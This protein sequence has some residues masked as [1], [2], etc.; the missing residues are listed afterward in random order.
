M[1]EYYLIEETVT[2]ICLYEI[3]LACSELHYSYKL[4]P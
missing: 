1:N 2:K 3:V 4:K